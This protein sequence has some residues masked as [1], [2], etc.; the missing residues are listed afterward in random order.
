[1]GC[2]KL[3]TDFCNFLAVIHAEKRHY[4]EK[5][6]VNY[7]P[8]GLE[9]KGYNNVVNGTENNYQTFLGQETNNELG[10]NWLTFR[11]RNYMPEIGRFFG[12]DPVSEDYMSI[13][14]YQFAHN[15]PIWKIELEGLEGV[16]VNN[17]DALNHEPVVGG[18]LNPASHMVLPIGDSTARN[19]G[20]S[21]QKSTRPNET[22]SGGD[23]RDVTPFVSTSADVVESTAKLSKDVNLKSIGN[24][25][26]MLGDI[27]TITDLSVK[28]YEEGVT[29]DLVEDVATNSVSVIGGPASPMIDLIVFDGKQ[30][31]GVTNTENLERSYSNSYRNNRAYV[32]KASLESKEKPKTDSK[33]GR[34]MLD[35]T[36]FYFFTFQWDEISDMQ[37]R[38][39]D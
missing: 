2:R 29:E 3:D 8:F 37:E 22:S 4:A 7:Y 23:Y 35:M 11:Y 24:K 32:Y 6:C 34:N 33:T 39:R 9:H 28:Y 1:M 12:V 17:F 31:D 16:P 14:T 26:G 15:N 25:A 36:I 30:E 13:S 27:Y 19:Y 20:S 21:D 5:K 10:L 38:N 18:S